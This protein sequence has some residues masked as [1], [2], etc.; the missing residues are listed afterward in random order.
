M[1]ISK[2][3]EEYR[4][5]LVARLFTITGWLGLVGSTILALGVIVGP[6]RS[7]EPM[8]VLLAIGIIS[9]VGFIGGAVISSLLIVTAK[10]IKRHKNYPLC[11]MVS[12]LA[13]LCIPV[14]TAL[15]IYAL[16]VLCDN[17][18]KILFDREKDELAI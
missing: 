2:T 9:F 6:L 16:V 17:S 18:V 13:C 11:V 1:N 15:G 12:G 14:G 3:L 5:S 7:D 10:M 4:L 8:D